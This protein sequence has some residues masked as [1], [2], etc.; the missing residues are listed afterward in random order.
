MHTY[1]LA[2][3]QLMFST[4]SANWAEDLKISG[5]FV[6]LLDMK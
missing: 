4:V 3:M 5:F 6:F 2:A 1:P